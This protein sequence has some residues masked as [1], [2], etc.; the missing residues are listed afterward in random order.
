MSLKVIRQFLSMLKVPSYI[1]EETNQS[2]RALHG[3]DIF[4][5]LYLT[6]TSPCCSLNVSIQPWN[7]SL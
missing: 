2:I 4:L 7:S 5:N 1:L 6:A 3:L